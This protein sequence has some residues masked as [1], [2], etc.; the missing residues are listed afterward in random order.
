MSLLRKLLR[1]ENDK[2]GRRTRRGVRGQINRHII[3][4]GVR[5][6]RTFIRK[7]VTVNVARNRHIPMELH[8]TKGWRYVPAWS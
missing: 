1:F 4:R 6:C 2:A 8:A 7:S 5:N 3:Q